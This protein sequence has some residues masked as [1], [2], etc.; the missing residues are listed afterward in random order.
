MRLFS[1]NFPSYVVYSDRN[2]SQLSSNNVGWYRLELEVED[3]AGNVGLYKSCKA[4]RVYQ[5][6][7]YYPKFSMSSLNQSYEDCG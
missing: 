5:I 7:S 1:S 2:N 4:L 6:W 3:M